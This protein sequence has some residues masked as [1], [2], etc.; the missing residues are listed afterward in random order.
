MNA[1][2]NLQ[3]KSQEAYGRAS[4]LTKNS[5]SNCVRYCAMLAICFRRVYVITDTVLAFVHDAGHMF[6][7]CD[8][9][10]RQSSSISGNNS[11]VA[12]VHDACHMCPACDVAT[13]SIVAFSIVSLPL[14]T[15]QATYV[16]SV[17]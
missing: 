4:V 2:M 10:M 15:M 17:T 13:K 9:T 8:S 11:I 6:P 12:F 7:A 5:L 3:R 1:S 14:C 16:Q